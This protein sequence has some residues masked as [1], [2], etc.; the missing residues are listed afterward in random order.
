V[1]IND[2]GGNLVERATKEEVEQACMEENEQWFRQANETPFM[3]SPLVE[4]F[5]CWNRGE[6]TGSSGGHIFPSF[7]DK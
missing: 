2:A 5:S 1:E 3:K 7:R 4:E 6:R